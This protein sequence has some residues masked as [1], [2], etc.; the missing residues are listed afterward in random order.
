MS[1]KILILRTGAIGDIILT[2]PLVL[3]CI[4]QYGNENVT[5][6]GP[7]Y[8]KPIA[9]LAG[10]DSC[11]DI[12]I[13]GIHKLYTDDFQSREAPSFFRK[14]DM[15]LNCLTG[16]ENILHKNLCMLGPEVRSLAPPDDRISMHA[17][18]YLASILP[19]INLDIPEAR[20]IPARFT[21]VPDG[22][23]NLFNSEKSIL[24]IHPGTGS[25]RKLINSD[26]FE[27]FISR[28]AK[29]KTI[30]ILTG[31]ADK[32]L[33]PFAQRMTAEYKG[34]H[35]HALPLE[36]AAYVLHRSSCYVGLDSGISHLAGL[37]DI[38]S[39]AVF[40]ATDPAVWKPFS[41]FVTVISPEEIE[42]ITI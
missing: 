16:E 7:G 41:S 40:S 18:E 11:I 30:I 5:L 19:E 31:P 37:I 10:I 3:S 1:K 34:V 24:T 12:D 6:V 26:M 32:A 39:Y 29:H 27:Q 25:P 15:I 33:V 36:Q 4:E 23:K 2:F 35:L 13:C 28:E 42:N 22:I 8:M 21:A 14:Q 17:A 9:Y 38:P 20:I